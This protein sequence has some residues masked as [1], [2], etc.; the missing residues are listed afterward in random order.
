[1]ARRK[2]GRRPARGAPGRLAVAAAVAIV[3]VGLLY[4]R[5]WAAAW[6]EKGLHIGMT[7]L[8]ENRVHNAALHLSR[9]RWLRSAFAL[10]LDAEF[11]SDLEYVYARALFEGNRTEDA[12]AQFEVRS[13]RSRVRGPGTSWRFASLTAPQSA[14]ILRYSTSWGRS[15]RCIGPRTRT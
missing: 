10:A 15:S 4:C 14:H 11:V 13:Y 6:V 8:E 3:G 7:E 5:G 2:L 9:A 12:I 1:M